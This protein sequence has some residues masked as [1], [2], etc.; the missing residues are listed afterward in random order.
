M[1]AVAN[2]GH[3]KSEGSFGRIFPPR[4]NARL[5][6]AARKHASDGERNGTR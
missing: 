6:M 3:G 4:L 2:G 5:F 1:F